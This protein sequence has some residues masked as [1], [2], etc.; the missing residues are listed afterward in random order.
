MPEP[1]TDIFARRA[2]LAEMPMRSRR[3]PKFLVTARHSTDSAWDT[4]TS[5]VPYGTWHARVMG[6]LQTVC[7][8]SAVTWRYFWTLDFANA[9]DRA[10]PECLRI[11]KRGTDQWGS[12]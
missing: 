7:G 9:G 4:D 10:C 3:W 2:Q 6:S 5:S 8:Q 1:R 11:A 12:R